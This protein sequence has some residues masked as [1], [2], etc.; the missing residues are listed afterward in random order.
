MIHELNGDDLE[1]EQIV[2]ETACSEGVIA[3][4][5]GVTGCKGGNRSAIG[6]E[7]VVTE[8]NEGV[9]GCYGDVTGR[10]WVEHGVTGVL[11]SDLSG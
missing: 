10:H 6:C 5:M 4:N 2:L 7:K 8:C 3:I 1:K 11:Q 9:T